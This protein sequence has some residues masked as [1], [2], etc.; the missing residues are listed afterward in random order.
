M[1]KIF[2]YLPFFVVA[3]FA[4]TLYFPKVFAKENHFSNVEKLNKPAIAQVISSAKR[5]RHPPH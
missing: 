4:T 2:D 1:K 3:L 5:D